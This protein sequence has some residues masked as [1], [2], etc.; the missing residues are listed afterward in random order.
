MTGNAKGA[1]SLCMRTEIAREN[2]VPAYI[3]FSDATLVDMCRVLPD[4]V[5]EMLSVNGIGQVKAQRYGEQ[6]LAVLREY[7]KQSR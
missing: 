2:K 4:S 3:V 1:V 5:D 6:F 7:R